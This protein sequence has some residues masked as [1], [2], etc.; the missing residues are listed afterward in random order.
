[1]ALAYVSATVAFVCVTVVSSVDSVT[2]VVSVSVVDVTVVVS[3]VVISRLVAI[4]PAV[5]SASADC[6]GTTRARH[7]TIDTINLLYL[8]LL[9]RFILLFY[10]FYALL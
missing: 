9:L 2:V 1:M 8:Y 10:T 3:S 5:F 6:V 4:A 7:A